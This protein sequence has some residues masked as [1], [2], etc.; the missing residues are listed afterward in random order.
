MKKSIL[1]KLI[2]I[3][4]FIFVFLLMIGAAK[5][6]SVTTDEGIHLLAGYTY[7]TRYD[8]RLD[9]EHPP[10]LKEIAAVPLLFFE[11]LKIPI[12]GLWEKAGNIYYDAWRETRTMAEEFLFLSGNDANK[13][14]F[15]GRLPFIILTLL[16]G[17]AVYY[18][19]KKIYG[20]KAGVF[21]A[22]LVL[23]MPNILAHGHLINTD[24][25]LSLFLFL[26]VFFWVKFLKATNWLNLLLSAVF[27]GLTLASKY[28]GAILIPIIIIL[29]LLKLVYLPCSEAD[30]NV[31]KKWWQYFL[32]LIGLFIFGTIIIWATYGFS[33][34]FP[35][36]FVK[37]ITFVGYHALGGHGSYLLGQSSNTGWW[38]YFP[39]A[40]WYKTSLPFFIFLILAIVFW[41][42]NKSKDTFDEMALIV[43]PFIFLVI[44]M[45]SKADLGVRH[46]LPIFPFLAVL[47]SRSINLIDFRAIKFFKINMKRIIPA[48]LFLLLM[49]WYLLSSI[50]SYP[51]YLAYFNESAGG[52][53]GGYKILGDSNL[54]WGQDIFRIKT[55]LDQHQI[56]NGFILYPWDGNDALK[57]YDIS[58]TP[59]PWNNKNIKGHLVISVTYYQLPE[60]R[61]LDVFPHEQIT[62][63]VLVFDL[64]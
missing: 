34:H 18:W 51:N 4:L 33:I 47:I 17:F 20:E 61:W 64:K 36:E 26:A 50:S 2:L 25:G 57:Y 6:D 31:F 54:D 11:D 16:L 28:T 38:Y 45:T 7:I 62:P 42:K 39:V 48:L 22:F 14:I 12:D 3:V 27:V 40:I 29:T 23:L 30:D 59:Y 13:I 8:F 63:G 5:Q 21:A 60:M 15:W 32:G 43:S 49:L 55:Y 56:S 52:P 35:A 58:L 44:S 19:A 9:P 24:L 41:K 10:F 46:V 53:K 1:A 37:G